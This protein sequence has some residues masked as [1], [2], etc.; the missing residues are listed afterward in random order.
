[1]KQPAD[2]VW[3]EAD[4][5]RL[6]Q[7]VAN[8]LNNAAKYTPDGGQISLDA[9]AM[10]ARSVIRVRDNGIGHRAASS[11]R[12]IFDLF[13]Q[14]D[15][16]LDRPEGG[17]GIGLTLV[18]TLVEM[19]GGSVRPRERGSRAG[20]ASSPSGCPAPRRPDRS[21]PHAAPPEAASRVPTRARG[22]RQQGRGRDASPGC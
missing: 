3:L 17:L 20:A 16:S 2:A 22:R 12:T 21:L 8:L 15:Q 10:A 6:E 1:M 14:G 11:C 5:A 19:H 13:I 7:A 9:E 4:P 18:R